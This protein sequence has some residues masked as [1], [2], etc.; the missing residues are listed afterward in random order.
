MKNF[1]VRRS[2]SLRIIS[3][4]NN[5]SDAETALAEMLADGDLNPE[6]YEVVEIA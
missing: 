2:D 1:V 4:W 3:T 6:D 5:L